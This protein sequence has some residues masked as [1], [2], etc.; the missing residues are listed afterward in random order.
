MV[1]YYID[2]E[3][4]LG[5]S[6]VPAEATGGVAAMVNKDENLGEVLVLYFP[7][8][9][10]SSLVYDQ[11]TIRADLCSHLSQYVLLE[12]VMGKKPLLEDVF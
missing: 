2:K 10:N 9:S 1:R 4:S 7:E 12:H 8:L 3:G 11:S 6:L 5:I